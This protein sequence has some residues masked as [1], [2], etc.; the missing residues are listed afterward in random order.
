M[1][2]LTGQIDSNLIKHQQIEKHRI[3][4]QKTMKVK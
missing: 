3:S 2:A 4:T 1:A